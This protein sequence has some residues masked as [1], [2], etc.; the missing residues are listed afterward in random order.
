M[1][2]RTGQG[3][4]TDNGDVEDRITETIEE[5]IPDDTTGEQAV[6]ISD[7]INSCLRCGYKMIE[8]KTC[9]LQCPN[10]GSVK[11]CDEKMVW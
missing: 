6:V 7:D 8:L 9:M 2:A 3:T 11:D 1:K 10:C 5:I 4:P